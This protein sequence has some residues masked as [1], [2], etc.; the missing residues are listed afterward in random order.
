MT[1]HPPKQNTPCHKLC[2]TKHRQV[3]STITLQRRVALRS[4]RASQSLQKCPFY[5]GKLSTAWEQTNMRFYIGKM[6]EVVAHWGCSCAWKTSL[7]IN[8]F[9]HSISSG[10]Y[11]QT[12]IF[13]YTS[14]DAYLQVHHALVWSNHTDKVEGVRCQMPF[15]QTA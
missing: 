11:L 3:W 9:V 4:P 15:S 2:G 1:R 13:R 14:P 8:H 7:E 12:H 10:A 6:F 5:S